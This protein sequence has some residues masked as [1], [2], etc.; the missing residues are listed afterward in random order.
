MSVPPARCL[1]AGFRLACTS[2]SAS[3]T[4]AR[5]RR[6]FARIPIR[7]S[8][9]S[10]SSAAH[11]PPLEALE[12]Y[13]RVVAVLDSMQELVRTRT[14]PPLE[15]DTLAPLATVPALRGW[16]RLRLD[17]VLEA[18]PLSA[19][20]SGGHA[21]AGPHGRRPSGRGDRRD[22]REQ[23]HRVLRV[24]AGGADGGAGDRPLPAGVQPG[25]QRGAHG[26]AAGAGPRGRPGAD[27]P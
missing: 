18:S 20:P 17:L 10:R 3:H 25:L 1:S 24:G 5:G 16:Q 12:L 4:R 23:R 26:V 6:W 11:P 13:F 2:P 15:I 19:S 22:S 27:H 7:P 14:S 9:S 8:S 21:P